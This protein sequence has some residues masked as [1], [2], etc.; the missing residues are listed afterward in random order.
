M[1]T[2]DKLKT[3]L[4]SVLTILIL[5]THAYAGGWVD[6]WLNQKSGSGPSSIEG[7]ERGFYS[8]GNMSVRWQDQST[9]PITTSLPRI[10]SGCGGIDVFMGGFSFMN[11]DFL[12]NKLQS[13]LSN[14]AGVAFDLGL[15]TLCEQCSNTIGKFE[16]ISD[17]LNQLQMTECAAGKSLVATVADNTDWK[18]TQAQ[19]SELGEAISYEKLSSGVSDMWTSLTKSQRASNNVP[20]AADTQSVTSGCGPGITTT[21]LQ[22]DGSLLGNL[23]AQM[24]LPTSYIDLMRGLVGDVRLNINQNHNVSYVPPCPQNNPDDLGAISTGKMYSQDVFETCSQVTDARKDLTDYVTK[25]LTSIMDSMQNKGDLSANQIA[26]IKTSPLST[27]PILKLAVATNTQSETLASMADVIAKA[28]ALQM[29]GD[30]Y[31]RTDNIAMKARELL[32]RQSGAAAG[33]KDSKCADATFAPNIDKNLASMLEQVQI[34]R[35][36]AQASY[37]TSASQLAAML[38]YLQTK[39]QQEILVDNMARSRFGGLAGSMVDH[40]RK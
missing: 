9:Y 17:T 15:K 26:F 34:R 23:G 3:L 21:F 35:K 36:A 1:Q 30:L 25:E 10:K 33:Q 13:I 16:A 32:A 37:N 22:E 7:Q 28:F 31:S 40:D 29:L 2:H 20:N 39:Q 4:V 8:G 6:D 24:G 11:S 5:S 27:L 38:Q 12:V 19:R 14:A 18:L